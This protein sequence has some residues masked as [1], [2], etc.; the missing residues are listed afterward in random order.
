MGAA[1]P[2]RAD[3]ATVASIGSTSPSG[4]IPV[5]ARSASF[6][7]T[8]RTSREMTYEASRKMHHD[9]W[10]VHG[11]LKNGLRPAARRQG[12]DAP[13]AEPHTSTGTPS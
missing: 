9:I 11:G 12:F 1:A 8:S 2:A 10:C 7:R 5:D 4:A 13:D 6:I 3:H